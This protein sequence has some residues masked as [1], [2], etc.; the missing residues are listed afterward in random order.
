MFGYQSEFFMRK[1]MFIS[2][3]F[4][5]LVLMVVIFTHRPSKTVEDEKV[6]DSV[7]EMAV[8]LDK[9]IGGSVSGQTGYVS[10]LS[11]EKDKDEFERIRAQIEDNL[12]GANL[13]LAEGEVSMEKLRET[14][15]V[16]KQTE[17]ML[18][19]LYMKQGVDEIQMEEY[20]TED[21]NMLSA[22]YSLMARRDPDRRRSY[23]DL[24]AGCIEKLFGYE[25]VRESSMY[26][27]R[28]LD[29]VSIKEELGEDEKALM[30]LRN[31]E[32]NNPRPGME[33]YVAHACIL[34]KAGGNGKEMKKLYEKMSDNTEFKENSRYG[35]L[36]RQMEIY[37]AAEG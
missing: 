29:L 15:G 1:L 27:P 11:V 36:R 19:D 12:Y 35:E 20:M 5:M 23:Y 22:I 28:L 10:G 26:E 37:L 16:L 7:S 2:A 24:A 9:G 31:F 14:A 32:E 30:Y 17:E 25:K 13:A 6:A 21:L 33:V 34:L 18:N 8:P 4:F 3:A